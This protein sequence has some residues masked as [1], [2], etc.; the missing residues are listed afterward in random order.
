MKKFNT[1]QASLIILSIGFMTGYAM[2]K[3]YLYF[4]FSENAECTQWTIIKILNYIFMFPF[5]IGSLI[6]DLRN[7]DGLSCIAHILYIFPISYAVLFLLIYMIYL[8]VKKLTKK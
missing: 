5:I 4:L 7:V 6:C 8:K 2:G 1:K 3:L